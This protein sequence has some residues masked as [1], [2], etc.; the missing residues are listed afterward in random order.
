MHTLD[1]EC[2]RGSGTTYK[3]SATGFRGYEMVQ[4]NL[5]DDE[6]Q[7]ANSRGLRNHT[8][9]CYACR[10]TVAMAQCVRLCTGAPLQRRGVWVA[11]GAG[12]LTCAVV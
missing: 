8:S 2:S 7:L 11:R 5:V 10:R 1:F 9:M 3:V 4:A 12:R 6:L